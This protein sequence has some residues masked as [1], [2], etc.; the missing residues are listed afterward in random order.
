VAQPSGFFLGQ[1]D[2]LDGLL[3]KPLEHGREPGH[4]IPTYQDL[5]GDWGSP[6][7]YGKFLGGAEDLGN[8][9]INGNADF[10][11]L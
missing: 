6:A 8:Y 2:H 10:T 9:A 11:P 3:G 5:R 4:V 1:H 7:Q